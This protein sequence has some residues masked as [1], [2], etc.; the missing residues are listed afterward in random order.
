[1]NLRDWCL[2]SK[3]ISL[4]N[5]LVKRRLGVHVIKMNNIRNIH[6]VGQMNDN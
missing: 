1:M 3:T 6:P 4:V 2:R 5:P